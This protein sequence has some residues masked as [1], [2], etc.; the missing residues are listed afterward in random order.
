MKTR[1]FEMISHYPLMD[2]IITFMFLKEI[3]II[4]QDSISSNQF[5]HL[6]NKILIYEDRGETS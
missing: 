1:K 5:P 4:I 6:T 2:L 3:V